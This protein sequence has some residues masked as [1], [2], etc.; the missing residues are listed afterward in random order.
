MTLKSKS[1]YWKYQM[2]Q[3][4]INS[5]H[6]NFGTNSGLTGAKY[7]IKIIFDFKID[8]NVFEIL[9]VPNFNKF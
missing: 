6:S 5:E 2:C 3:I 9:H 1:V 4:S 7:L 8:I